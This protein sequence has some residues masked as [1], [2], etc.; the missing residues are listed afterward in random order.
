VHS[1]T[2]SDESFVYGDGIAKGGEGS[3]N[4]SSN[5]DDEDSSSS[6]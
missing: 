5:D 1:V 4:G 3:A 2:L 6:N